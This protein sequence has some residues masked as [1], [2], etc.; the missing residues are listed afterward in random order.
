[1]ESSF[2][3]RSPSKNRSLLQQISQGSRYDCIVLNELAVISSDSQYTTQILQIQWPRPISYCLNLGF[4][5]GD[6]LRRNHMPQI[7]HTL[8][9]KS[10]LREL[11]TPLV[12]VQDFKH[13]SQMLEVLLI[14]LAIDQDIVKENKGE[15]VQHR[16]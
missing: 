7:S 6:T 16:C 13:L 12:L 2:S 1:M 5:C 3:F 9:C 8:L 10:T 4:I 11:D 14:G 15:L